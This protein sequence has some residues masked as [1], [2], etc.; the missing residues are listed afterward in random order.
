[1]TS[2]LFIV[3][4]PLLAAAIAGLGNRAIGNT[5]AKSVTTGALF[6]SC[7]LS[8]PIFIGFM[9]GSLSATVT[10]VLHFIH[11]GSFDELGAARRCADGGDAGGHHQRLRARP[12]L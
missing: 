12:P 5:V 11:S 8:W 2:I 4:L 7:A 6:I 9:T 10:P 1:M 3:F